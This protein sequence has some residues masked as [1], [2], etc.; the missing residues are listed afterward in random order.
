VKINKLNRP[1]LIPVA[2]L[3][4]HVNGFEFIKSRRFDDRLVIPVF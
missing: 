2:G 4:E 3:S 1:A